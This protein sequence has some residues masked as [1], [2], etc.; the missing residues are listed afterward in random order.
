MEHDEDLEPKAKRRKWIKPMKS[1]CIMYMYSIMVYSEFLYCEQHWDKYNC[2]EYRG[3]LISGVNLYYKAQ[4]GTF[5]S[6]INTGVSS[7][8]GVLNR[9]VS[10]YMYIH[11]CT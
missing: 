3:V 11:V 10:L 6:V 1:K 9:G 2:P 8:Q 7:F 4:F 5:V